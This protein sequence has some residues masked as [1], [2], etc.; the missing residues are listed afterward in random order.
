MF[1]WFYLLLAA[2]CE[3]LWTYSLK[4]LTFSSLKTLRWHNFYKAD[5]GL[6][7]LL[8][9]LGYIGFGVANIYFFST[10]IKRIPTP[11]AF[12]VWMA[13]SLILIKLSDVFYYKANWSFTEVFFVMMIVIGI[14]GLKV[15]ATP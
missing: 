10:A 14:V 7:V 4:A 9:L 8:P 6:P 15:Y 2:I 11:T 13:L 3:T 5:G 12:A 1:Y